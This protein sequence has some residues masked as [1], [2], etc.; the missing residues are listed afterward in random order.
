M[1]MIRQLFLCVCILLL[2]S[3]MLIAQKTVTGT[4]SDASGL[5]PGVSIVEKGTGNGVETDFEGF[6]TIKVSKDNAILSIRYL[7]YK[8][9]EVSVLGKTKVAICPVSQRY[10]F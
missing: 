4:I 10:C 8:V 3:S 5:L 2:S 1:N 6:F 9:K 7:G